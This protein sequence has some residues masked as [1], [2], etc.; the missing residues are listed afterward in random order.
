MPL[1]GFE[2][3][4]YRLGGDRSIQLSY[5][6]IK[7]L[8]QKCSGLDLQFYRKSA[9]QP[10]KLFIFYFNTFMYK[11]IAFLLFW[12]SSI[13]LADYSDS[14]EIT[15]ITKIYHSVQVKKPYQYCYEVP[16]NQQHQDI[17]DKILANKFFNRILNSTFSK[18]SGEILKQD[19]AQFARTL[20]APIAKQNY[21]TAS[22]TTLTSTQT[23]T[24]NTI[25]IVKAPPLQMREVCEMR[26]RYDYEQR[27]SYYL[28]KYN[29]KGVDH[30]YQSRHKPKKDTVNLR[31]NVRVVP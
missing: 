5:K 8:H 14:A 1:S 17:S 25:P 24:N 29:Y 15:N 19:I 26:Y 30:T 18:Q 2:P 23:T 28:I 12:L 4:T 16:I 7:P 9:H 22:S 6:G 3:K 31:V 21:P 11:L 20:Y 27:L 13:A 10:V